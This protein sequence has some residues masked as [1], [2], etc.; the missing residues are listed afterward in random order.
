MGS[1]RLYL[2]LANGNENRVHSYD[3]ISVSFDLVFIT[4]L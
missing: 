1:R 4:F 3:V 2:L